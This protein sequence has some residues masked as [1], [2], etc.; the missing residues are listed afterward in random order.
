LLAAI[1][2]FL[3]FLSQVLQALFILKHQ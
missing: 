2:Y 3:L 1:S